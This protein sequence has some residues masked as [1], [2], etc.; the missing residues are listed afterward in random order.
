MK[1]TIRVILCLG[2]CSGLLLGNL[3]ATSI[4]ANKRFSDRANLAMRQVGHQL[5][6][7]AGD[8]RST[9][10]PVQI[11]GP[12]EFTL[13]L[14]GAFNYDTLPQLLNQAFLSYGI[15]EDYQVTVKH[16]RFSDNLG[17]KA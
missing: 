10:P 13:K 7:L 2:L 4:E 11:T 16:C 5:L 15:R 9:I 6:Q 17:G 8:E 3:N 12:G 1:Q 14:E